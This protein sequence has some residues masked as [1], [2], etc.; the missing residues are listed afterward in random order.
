M[1]F[2]QREEINA[3]FEYIKT[4]SPLNNPK[5]AENAISSSKSQHKQ[6]FIDLV[7]FD[8]RDKEKNY[9]ME[10]Q[11]LVDTGATCSLI[12]YPTYIELAKLQ[13]LKPVKT[14]VRT[15]GINGD[16]LDILGFDYIIS[17]FDIEGKYPIR[18]KVWI[19]GPGGTEYNILG[20]DFLS[21]FGETLKFSDLALSLKAY[22]GQWV[23]MSPKSDKKFPFISEVR[24]FGLSENITIA[25]NSTRVVSIYPQTSPKVFP[26]GTTFRLH[27]SVRDAGIYTFNVYCRSPESQ[28]PIMLNNPNSYKI[29]LPSE[30]L[31]YTVL[32]LDR[33][34]N[35]STI[36]SITNNIAFVDELRDNYPQFEEHFEVSKVSQTVYDDKDLEMLDCEQTE[37]ATDFSAES[38][39]LRPQAEINN[40][41]HRPRQLPS[42]FF[43][44]FHPEDQE[45]LKKFDFSETELTDDELHLLFRILVNDQD[46]YS[47]H[48]Y[49][50]GKIQQKFHVKLKENSELK[51]Q[52]ASRVPLHYQSKLEALLEE[53]QRADIIRE[54]GD[55]IEMG[56]MF[57]N[58]I[59][60]LPKGDTIKLVIDARY[61]NSIT[62]L[63]SY[64]WP[65][66][67][68]NTM[69]TRINGKYF[70]TSDLLSAYNQVPLTNETQKLASFVIGSKQFTFKRGFYG[71]CGLPNFF[72]RIMTIQFAPLIKRK[73]AITYIDDTLM[74]AET[75][76][77]MMDIIQ[78]YHRLLRASGL[79]AAPE[80][81]NFFLR[82]VQFL[83]HVVSQDGIQPV[84]KKVAALKAL[85]S[86]ENKRDVMRVLGCLGFY[87]S[88]IKNLHVDSKPFHE[89]TRDNVPFVWTAEHENLFNDLK[90]RISEDTILA[91]PSERYPFH[92]HV[93]SSSVGTGCILVQEFPEGKGIVSFNS[94]IFN[95]SEQKMSTMHRELCGIVSALQTYEHLII[96]SPFPIYV[97]CD[98]KPILYLWARRGKLSHRF[99]RYQL[100]ITQFQNLKII[101]T[102]G[103]NL[104]FPDILSR[105]LSLKEIN[106]QQLKHKRI[107]KEIKFFDEN[108]KEIKYFINHD[109]TEARSSNDFFPIIS[110][111]N[112]T[113]RQIFFGN[114]MEHS[115]QQE[116]LKDRL[117]S[118]TDLNLCFQQGRHINQ[119]RKLSLSSTDSESDSS[120]VYS[121]IEMNDK[122]SNGLSDSESDT[123]ENDEHTL[124]AQIDNQFLNEVK[125]LQSVQGTMNVNEIE[126]AFVAS[127]VDLNK[128][129]AL[130]DDDYSIKP[131]NSDLIAKEQANDAVLSEVRTWIEKGE[132]PQRSVALRHSKGLMAYYNRFESLAI[133][134]E[135]NLVVYKEPNMSSDFEQKICL[136]RSLFLIVSALAHS[137]PLAGHMGVEKTL[138]T[139]KGYFYWPGMQKWVQALVNDCLICQKNKHKPSQPNQAPLENWNDDIPFPMHTVHIDH[140]G[141]LNPSS[142]GKKH[143]LV[144]VDA[145]S[146]F[147]QVYAVK[148]T[149]AS[150]TIKA[151]EKF[152]TSFGIPQKLVYDR[153][154]A[155]MNHDF[156][157]WLKEMG[158]THAPRTAYSPW[159]NGKVEI[160]NK[161]LG[162]YFRQFISDQGT[163]WS[164]LVGNFAFAH[165]T[166]VNYGTGQTPYEIVFG[167]KPQIPLSMKLGLTRNL[168]LNCSAQFCEGLPS[169]QHS[170]TFTKNNAVNPLLF[171]PSS[172]NLIHR[173]NKFKNTYANAYFTSINTQDRSHFYRNRHKLGQPLQVGQKFFLRITQ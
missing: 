132:K 131:L 91:I 36:Y 63:S 152:I 166:S 100:I 82:K 172:S 110:H 51:K 18:H 138:L 140:K 83:G 170:E 20:N 14:N 156:T 103:K 173:E 12:N 84:A 94:R 42:K 16:E 58:P 159:T 78:E 88:Y 74:Q 95:K 69:L 53:L 90:D 154:T 120:H 6:L 139:L 92:I 35:S 96:G 157:H 146:R 49:D 13:N 61:L 23:A 129:L 2:D 32:D 143:C 70:T 60:I 81:T 11:F 75:K 1:H 150:D 134:P 7:Q 168:D 86:P 145:F 15:C 167:Q 107:P 24:R 26:P 128:D 31:G 112:N 113:T 68:L 25:P 45:F 105:N 149:S 153:G 151:L 57:I 114:K 80:K 37:L 169:H 29:T 99:F 54:M 122:E 130:A 165:N 135:K 147:V 119:Q 40:T 118:I 43:K 121:E 44:N 38:K 17:N 117:H 171:K 55:D 136:P 64:S 73:K 125:E 47:H 116:Y 27:K 59:I 76:P 52:R 133:E 30:K 126:S 39:S 65:L 106:K 108:G 66:E 77:E 8:L 4:K 85:K 148:P 123:G 62:D 161:H 19:F 124:T 142:K 155:F 3:I 72:S 109:D 41:V 144:V 93:D 21:Q 79:K 5:Q 163:N 104:A 137:H 67:P 98:H 34:Q 141:P 46:V 160:Q 50:V 22:P 71:L 9:G 115:Y 101:W 158:I 33:N 87:S 164:E 97:Y 28:I 48:K 162:R 56:S 10:A 111:Q 89:L 102:P 127:I